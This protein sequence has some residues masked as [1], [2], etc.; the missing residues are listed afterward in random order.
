M[1]TMK[2]YCILFSI[3]FFA[4]T[5]NAKFILDDIAKMSVEDRRSFFRDSS[6]KQLANPNDLF[7]FLIQG[8]NDKDPTVRRFA[9][10]KTV[11]VMIGLQNFKLK[12]GGDIPIDTSGLPLVQETLVSLIAD[13]DA[14]VRGAVI[15]ALAYSDASNERIESIL[16]N[17]LPQEPSGDLRSVILRTMT[18]V[19][20]ESEEFKQILLSSLEDDSPK[21]RK[22]AAAGIAQV[23][24]EGALLK[25]AKFLQI[26]TNSTI[27]D[28]SILHEISDAFAAYGK[29]AR[30]YL[31]QLESLLTNKMVSG[32]A[33]D[34]IRKAIE[35]IKN[36]KPQT[37]KRFKTVSLIDAS[38]SL[39]QT[40]IS[41]AVTSSLPSYSNPSTNLST[42]ETKSSEPHKI[43][44]WIIG[45]IILGIIIFQLIRKK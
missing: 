16:L 34:R 11:N 15:E 10:Q 40:N 22:K 43:W 14:Q 13:S 45:G 5:A 37:K 27:H 33:P 29:E 41:Q 32:T 8:M 2:L 26:N 19:G 35:A 24:P 30:P 6:T 31:P 42:V 20:Y 7:P 39:P 44:P 1:R 36:P 38:A 12:K 4:I 23:K 3:I 9:T 17:R 28:L 18:F 21:V 25:L